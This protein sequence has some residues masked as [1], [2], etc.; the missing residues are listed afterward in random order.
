MPVFSTQG[1]LAFEKVPFTNSAGW[2]TI[3]TTNNNFNDF[4]FESDGS[5]IHL[6]TQSP[7]GFT[8]KP[9]YGYSLIDNSGLLPSVPFSRSWNIYSLA[10]PPGVRI[11]S[12]E[13]ECFAVAVEENPGSSNNPI[14]GGY[15]YGNT[16]VAGQQF[17]NLYHNVILDGP[18]GNPNASVEFDILQPNDYQTITRIENVS[19]NTSYVMG[20]FVTNNGGIGPPKTPPNHVLFFQ[21]IDTTLFVDPVGTSRTRYLTTIDGTYAVGDYDTEKPEDLQVDSNGSVILT[22]NTLDPLLN[23]KIATI[24]KINIVGVTGVQN[25][26]GITIYNDTSQ[27]LTITQAAIDSNDNVYVVLYEDQGHTS[28]IVKTSSSGVVQYRQKM[29]NAKLTSIVC[30]Q[31]DNIYVGGTDNLT[32]I[33]IAKLDSS[34][35]IVWQN[36]LYYSGSYGNVLNKMKIFDNYLYLCGNAILASNGKGFMAKVPLNGSIPGNGSYG[37]VTY[38]TSVQAF[39]APVSNLITTLNSATSVYPTRLGGLGYT[40]ADPS[41]SSATPIAINNTAIA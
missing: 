13:G 30:D 41:A 28:Y 8:N 9:S 11:D 20:T 1:G 4:V 2:Y 38:G 3:S 7:D 33:N 16:S 27:T 10:S 17:G 34:G 6:A 39:L 18:Q 36:S 26:W 12:I 22:Y 29:I 14:L 40:A 5:N 19:A 23:E 24:G 25:A 35:N 31:S 21:E 15:I 32:K 37:S